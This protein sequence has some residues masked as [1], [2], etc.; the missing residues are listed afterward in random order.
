MEDGAEFGRYRIKSPLGRG[1]MAE[2]LLA[3]QFGPS[4]FVKPCVIK[5][6]HPEHRENT[7]LKTMFQK[8]AKISA[9]LNHPNIVQ[10]FDY[11]EIDDVPYMA[12]E[13][14]EG[15]SLS[16]MNLAM[17][18]LDCWWN[19]GSAIDIALATGRALAYAHGLSSS[20]GEE[21]GLVH[22]D[23][24]PQNILVSKQGAVKLADFGI[25]RVTTLEEETLLPGVKGKIGYMA[26]EQYFDRIVDARSDLFSLGILLAELCSGRRV[27]K[28][29]HGLDYENLG[30]RIKNLLRSD[31]YPQELTDTIIS[32]TKSSPDERPDNLTIACEQ[33][34]Q[35]RPLI[36]E[37]PSL[38]KTVR[39]VF[40]LFD[41]AV[42]AKTTNLRPEYQSYS[43]LHRSDESP[44]R[45]LASPE[46]SNTAEE[47]SSELPAGDLLAYW[48]FQDRDDQSLGLEISDVAA[49]GARPSSGSI[50]LVYSN[51]QEFF[52]SDG[53]IGAPQ[54]EEEPGLELKLEELKSQSSEAREQLND[55]PNADLSESARRQLEGPTLEELES[56]LSEAREQLKDLPSSD[57]AE[58]ARPAIQH[59]GTQSKK[60]TFGIVIGLFAVFGVL[61]LLAVFSN[62]SD[63][64]NDKKVVSGAVKIVSAPAGADI[65]L[66]GRKTGKQTPAELDDLPLD[67]P[68]TIQLKATSAVFE[69]KSFS[70]SETKNIAELNFKASSSMRIIRLETVPA[71][72]SVKL[73]FLELPDK[74]PLELPP[75]SQNQ[76]AT[77]SISKPGFMTHQLVLNAETMT[78]SLASVTL[79]AS[80]Q[81]LIQ[82]TPPGAEIYVNNKSVGLSPTQLLELPSQST[83]TLR[84]ELPKHIPYSKTVGLQTHVGQ[85]FQLE[86][87]PTRLD[88]TQLSAGQ[89]KKLKNLEAN[90]RRIRGKLKKARATL[91][92]AET[93]L[94]SAQSAQNSNIE[95]LT[96]KFKSAELV[97]T[98]VTN[99]SDALQD[100]LSKKDRYLEDLQ[101]S[102]VEK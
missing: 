101:S 83:F 29:G 32:W 28:K 31:S 68:M 72:A 12:M 69:A 36:Q 78:S 2:V 5:R 39:S 17:V 60:S 56:Q 92:T 18:R 62:S 50:E 9:L 44:N 40:E 15:L 88:A 22:R 38:N 6:I 66:N 54:S 67:V 7:V 4:G 89:Q 3:T 53:P 74:T 24:S 80:R 1:G 19:L 45:Q 26:P 87:N 49:D 84:A 57:L 65:F 63:E 46:S 41:D 11:G 82:T 86:L 51:W 13:L 90:I 61:A 96:K 47:E 37:S 75:L 30:T 48:D 71:G 93:N 27:R 58:L 73:N 25:A 97:R 99:L 14:V 34:E 10:T 35:L 16:A 95:N 8:E 43:S 70:L 91:R 59:A 42:T 94:N 52:D 33:L 81:I 85:V 100:A 76:T 21:L 23:V 102:V 79:E 98:H 55:L 64:Q 20:E 77:V